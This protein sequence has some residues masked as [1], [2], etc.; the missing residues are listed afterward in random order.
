VT[1]PALPS[2]QVSVQ[3]EPSPPESSP[4][5]SSIAEPGRSFIVVTGTPLTV[6]ATRPAAQTG[7][8]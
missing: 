1:P 3:D 4:W 2:A 7:R 6:A 5:A 8:L